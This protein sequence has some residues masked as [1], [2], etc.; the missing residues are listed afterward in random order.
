[1]SRVKGPPTRETDAEGGPARGGAW[2]WAQVGL[3]STACVGV[4]WG[5]RH[6]PSEPCP[7]LHAQV[8]SGS[9]EACAPG[10]AIF[11]EPERWRY[12][13][14]LELAPPEGQGGG[15]WGLMLRT[16]EQG[17]LGEADLATDHTR[18]LHL[19]CVDASLEDYQHVHP[20]FVGGGRWRF[21]F[22]PRQAG[23]YRFYAEAVPLKTRRLVIA[24]TE[25]SVAR[26]V[27]GGGAPA[28]QAVEA[29]LETDG[30]LEAGRATRLRLRVFGSDGAPSQ[31]E[32]LMGALA[33]V[34]IFDRQR[35]G[36]AH[37]HPVSG[38]EG[39]RPGVVDFLFTAP[40]PGAY[41]AWAQVRVAGRDAYVPFEL[42]VSA[43]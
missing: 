10:G 11:V 16:A 20:E 35:P 28:S 40:A 4:F 43:P 27:A 7:L 38:G 15:E 17:T 32:P 25:A 30:P 34:A 3:I 31:L 26:P 22:H 23:L 24:Q 9:Q 1:M 39:N 29:R 41:R 19:L 36:L 21:E 18:K 37:L 14:T 6:L 13:V 5:L 33:H 12:P 2:R 8:S 42:A